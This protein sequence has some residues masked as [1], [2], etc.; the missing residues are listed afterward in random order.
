MLDGII[1][2]EDGFMVSL[3]VVALWA[4]IHENPDTD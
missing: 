2:V 4:C 3:A 1:Q